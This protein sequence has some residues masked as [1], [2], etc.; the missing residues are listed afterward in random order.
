MKSDPF[1]YNNNDIPLG[2][3]KYILQRLVSDH[4]RGE[5]RSENY[6]VQHK[7]P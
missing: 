3:L 4:Q 6:L 1:S 2:S 5:E 7:V